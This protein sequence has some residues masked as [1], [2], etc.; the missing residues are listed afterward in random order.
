[1]YDINV[2][3]LIQLRAKSRGIRRR[4]NSSEIVV[5]GGL[6]SIHDYALRLMTESTQVEAIV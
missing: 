3:L 4:S 2:D 1:M 5:A 6:E